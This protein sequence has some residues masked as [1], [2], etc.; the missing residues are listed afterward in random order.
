MKNI[1]TTFKKFLNESNNSKKTIYHFTESTESLIDI[2]K[3]DSLQQGS[4]IGN[5]GLGYE[6]ISFTW[7]PKLWS[8]EYLGD[9]KPRWSVRISFDYNKMKDVWKFE[10]FDY[11]IAEE[12]EE[13]VQTDEMNGIKKYITEIAIVLDK[14]NRLEREET[15]SDIEFIKRKYPHALEF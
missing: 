14:G 6:N 15:M 3:S 4:D 12:M 5:F 10:P 9:T 7:N 1:T 13:I 2:L 8:I 11:G